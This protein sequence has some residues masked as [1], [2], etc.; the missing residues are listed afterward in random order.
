MKNQKYTKVIDVYFIPDG[1]G[2]YYLET[3][4]RGIDE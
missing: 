2:N 4:E 3:R 1:K